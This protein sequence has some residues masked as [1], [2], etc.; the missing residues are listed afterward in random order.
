MKK[1]TSSGSGQIRI[2]GGQWRGRKLPVTDSP[3]LRPTTDRVRETLF[4][5]LAPYMVDARCLDCFAGSGAL[6]LESLSRYA[7]S[8]TLL[9]MERP[10]AQQLQKNLATLKAAHGKVVNT[11]TLNY[12]N[13]TG[14]PHDIVFIDPPFRKGLLDETLSLL[15]KN[16]WLAD[17]ALIYVESEVENGMPPVPA[18]WQLH[19]E[20][21]A[22]QVAYRLYL[23]ETQGA[24]H[25]D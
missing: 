15:E 7:A 22:G 13:Q 5:W 2:I 10:V 11:N 19:R 14:T 1:P 4:N 20:K 25:A 17:G 16:G 12:L 3:G 8:A 21:V 6:G 24:E 18:S 23:R 9:E